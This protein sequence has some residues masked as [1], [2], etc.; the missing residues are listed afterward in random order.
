MSITPTELTA[1][2]AADSGT[3][4][5]VATPTQ[6]NGVNVSAVIEC[7]STTRALLM[8]RM[9]T[10]QKNAIAVKVN[11]MQVFDTDL[12]KVDFYQNNAWIGGIGSGDVVGPNAASNNTLALFS[13]TTG[14][15]IQASTVALDP[16][17]AVF[18]GIASLFSSAGTA[19]APTYS[20]TGD[21][22]TGMYRIGANEIGFSANGATQLSV[23]GSASAT[24]YVQ[25]Q[26]SVGGSAVT[27][28]AAGLSS[29]IDIT[30]SPKGTGRPINL[31]NNASLYFQ[32]ASIDVTPSGTIAVPATNYLGIN[33]SGTSPFAFNGRGVLNIGSTTF[34]STM[35]RGIS[36]EG[37]GVVPT[38]VAN[39]LQIY[40]ATTAGGTNAGMLGLS[41][42]SE[43]ITDSTDT[44]TKK[45]Q[46]RVNGTVYYLLATDV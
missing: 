11:G 34:D 4:G 37:T 41:I 43:C 45:I 1:L 8:P 33:T 39:K 2:L 38:G 17:S 26:G 21:A 30:I 36:I 3:G 7:Q 15:I 35:V 28:G 18:T 19:G 9:T 13:G 46:L 16:L 29:I 25:L 5:A 40:G 42:P 10:A 44:A 23:T 12:G 27:I 14:K 22:D 31:G 6:V 32:T 24:N 20:F